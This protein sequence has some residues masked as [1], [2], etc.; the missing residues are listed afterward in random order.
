LSQ[1]MLWHRVLHKRHSVVLCP[2]C[3][4]GS[5]EIQFITKSFHLRLLCEKKLVQMMQEKIS[6]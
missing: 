5:C 1:S 2:V 6:S 4:Y 3:L